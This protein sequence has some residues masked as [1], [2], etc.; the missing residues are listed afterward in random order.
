MRFAFGS[1]YAA[2]AQFGFART[3]KPYDDTGI[4]HIDMRLTL[5]DAA[6]YET[7]RAAGGRPMSFDDPTIRFYRE[8]AAAYVQR[9]Q[10]SFV[11]LQA[12][13]SELP[14]GAKILELGC[15]SGRHSAEMIA[16]GF[17]VRATDG[18]PEMAE[19]AARRL[20]RP[21]ETLRFDELDEREEYD[22]VWASACLLHV[23]TAH[24]QGVLA[25]IWRALKMGGLFYASFKEGDT[26][27]RDTIGRYYNYPSEDWL[28]QC[29]RNAGSW[30][31]RSIDRS[32][33][34]GFDG[35]AA[36]MMHLVVQKV[37]AA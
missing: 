1:Q 25:R 26:D 11:R 16:G 33:G 35:T 6:S 30:T 23:P 2:H 32:E 8:N 28:R 37:T 12:F 5:R 29:Y 7:P 24:L 14:R 10:R 22:A 15:G 9:P 19:E 31:F 4:L 13:L 21:V 3:S 34:K 18:S 17:D 20:G 27:G 36:T